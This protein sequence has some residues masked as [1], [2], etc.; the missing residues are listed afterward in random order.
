MRRLLPAACLLTLCLAALP[1]LAQE[2]LLDLTM[3]VD[4]YCGDPPVSGML[5][6]GWNQ[7]TI[8]SMCGGLVS[9]GNTTNAYGVN[10]TSPT[11]LTITTTSPAL[12]VTI[13]SGPPWVAS[14][15]ATWTN[16]MANPSLTICLPA[17]YWPIQLSSPL[18]IITPYEISLACAPCE[19]VGVES[20]SWGA[21]KGT[22]R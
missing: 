18:D 21:L 7:A 1:A 13:L 22:F 20:R 8:G 17:G 15:C 3:T 10:L 11:Q 2:P 14:S 4:L 16:L 9:T 6:T 5:G 19:P 12:Q